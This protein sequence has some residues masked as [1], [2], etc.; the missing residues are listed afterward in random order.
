M[1][2]SLQTKSPRT[3]PTN[4]SLARLIAPFQA[5]FIS[6]EAAINILHQLDHK[7]GP[8]PEELPLM[9]QFASDIIAAVAAG[10]IS[11]E[12]VREINRCLG[13]SYLAHSVNGSSLNKPEGYPGDFRMIERV[14]RYTVT[15]K[16]RYR[17]WD[18]CFHETSAA[19]AVRNRKHYFRAKA[20]RKIIQH[21]QNAFSIL[22]LA[23]GPAREIYELYQCFHQGAIDTTC[24]DADPNALQ[25][26]KNLLAEYADRIQYQNLNVFRY[27]PKEKYNLIWSAG[28]FD[29]LNDKLFV[30]LLKKMKNWLKPAGEIIIGNFS[31]YHPSRTYME[32]FGEWYLHHRSERQLIALA[33]QAGYQLPEIQIGRESEGVNLFLHLRP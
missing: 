10:E 33:Q 28:M 31:T 12:E 26:A 13:A 27:R 14:Y 21:Q 9:Q 5:Q 22:A 29:Y 25:Y 6:K 23:S 30:Y 18:L 7:G 20:A 3:L 2:P 24:L 32:V 16:A 17:N 19:K 11:P 1:K 8:S 15:E 4:C